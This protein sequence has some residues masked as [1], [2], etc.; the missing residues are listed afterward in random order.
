M[1]STQFFR[2]SPFFQSIRIALGEGNKAV[3]HNF[4]DLHDRATSAS[5]YGRV[6]QRITP[7]KLISEVDLVVGLVPGIP[8]RIQGTVVTESSLRVVSA[9]TMEVSVTS[10]QVK[11][12]NVPLLNQFMDDLKFE[13]PVG[14]LYK[15][16]QG[17]VPTVP[18]RTFYVDEAIRI[19]R[20]IDDNF[21]VFTRA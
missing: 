18:L 13:L 10:T 7:D 17:S 11:G 20:D 12:S 9:E 5:R 3:A 14:N 2:S 16:V 21:F 1:S 19:T 15:T 8:V 4:F 6:R